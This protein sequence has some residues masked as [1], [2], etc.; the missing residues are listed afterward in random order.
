MK[1]SLPEVKIIDITRLSRTNTVINTENKECFVLSCRLFG[2]SLFYY[3]N[4]VYKV[5]KGDVLFVP[6]HASYSQSCISEEVVCFHLETNS[7][8]PKEIRIF[9]PSDPNEMCNMFSDAYELCSSRIYNYSYLC[10]SKLYKILGLSDILTVKDSGINER[11]LPAVEYIEQNL[12]NNQLSFETAC[13]KAAISRI[14]FNKLFKENFSVTPVV[15]VNKKRIDRAKVLLESG[16][17]TREEV[18]FQCGFNDV[19]Y[20]YTVFKK[21]TGMTTGKYI[22]K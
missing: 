13:I 12:Y 5:E 11:L 2:E 21:Y 14:Y 6:A 8:V 7:N 10:M 19:K 1:T 3:N 15:Y 17:Y 20:F 16:I 18:A 22:E 9:K 4:N